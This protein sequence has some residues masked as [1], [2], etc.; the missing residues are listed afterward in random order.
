MPKIIIFVSI[1]TPQKPIKHGR[2]WNVAQNSR[3]SPK[4]SQKEHPK[5]TLVNSKKYTGQQQKDTLFETI[6]KNQ[7]NKIYVSRIARFQFL[8]SKVI[9]K[10][11]NFERENG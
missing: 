5:N 1:W 11:D 10:F 6:W 3:F 9:S 4:M 7:Y 8:P 2:Y